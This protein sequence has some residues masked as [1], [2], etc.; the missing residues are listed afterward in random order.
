MRAGKGF[1]ALAGSQQLPCLAFCRTGC[2]DFHHN[3]P[4]AGSFSCI[5]GFFACCPALLAGHG[6]DFRTGSRRAGSGQIGYRD[7]NVGDLV[8]HGKV[9]AAG[10][11]QVEDLLELRYRRLGGGALD[12][13]CRDLGDGGEIVRNAVQLLLNGPHA[14]PLAANGQHLAAVG[15]GYAL[16]LLRAF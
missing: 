13:V 7:V 10:L 14:L 1:S 11:G 15:Q 3:T 4:Y 6:K 5:G 16:H 12:P 2:P 8:P 9:Y